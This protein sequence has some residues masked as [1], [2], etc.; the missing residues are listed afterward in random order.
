MGLSGGIDS[1]LTAVIAVDAL[2]AENVVGISMPSQ[3]SSEGSIVDARQLAANL[4]IRF[5]VVAIR[6]IFESYRS[7]LSG[8]FHGLGE[9]RH[10]RKSSGPC[11]WWNP[12]GGSEQ[13]LGA[14][15]HHRQQE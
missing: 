9:G 11:P 2:G 3:Y 6:E 7:A 8:I 10:R 14:R 1:A 4:G 15:P 13:V 5:E 12:D